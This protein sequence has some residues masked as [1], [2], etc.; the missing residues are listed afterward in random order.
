MTSN[1]TSALHLCYLGSG[2]ER[3]DE[4]LVPSLTFIGTINPLHYLG[5][6]PHFVDVDRETMGVDPKKLRNYLADISEKD[7]GVLKNKNTGRTIRALIVM[8]TF[9]H[10]VDLKG[11]KDVCDEYDLELIEDAAEALG[12]KFNGVHV[13]YFGKCGA[14]S[15]NGNKI[16]TTGGGGALLTNDGNLAKKLKHLSTTAKVSHAYEFFHDEIGFNYRMTN[17]N[18]A[19]GVAQLEQINEFLKAKKVLA[20]KYKNAFKDFEQGQIFTG[21]SHSESNEWIT[22][23]ILNNPEDRDIILT[24]LNMM[25]IHCRPIWT[26]MHRLPMNKDFPKMD[27]SITEFL[28]ERVISLPSSVGLAK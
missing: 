6:V 9:G 28:Y 12:S 3:G 27:L 26:P 16:M 15:F 22:N 11:C 13:G 10:S 5:A 18:A 21:P 19:L 20:E 24:E 17:L 1:G 25:K 2:I 14:L 7:G 23:I 8:H 4:V